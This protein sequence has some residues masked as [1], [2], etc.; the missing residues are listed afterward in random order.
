MGKGIEAFENFI[1][2]SPILH[3]NEAINPIGKAVNF[4]LGENATTGIRGV[5]N[6]IGSD[7]FNNLAKKAY[8]NEGKLNAKAVAGTYVGASIAAR[9]VGGGGIYRDRN[10]NDDL[11]GVPFL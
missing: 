9:A 4:M 11:V 2:S 1:K 6:A 8:Y 7:D 10:G 3:S 5:V